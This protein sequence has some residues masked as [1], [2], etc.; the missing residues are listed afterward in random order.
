M[1]FTD[2]LVPPVARWGPLRWL[3]VVH[4]PHQIAVQPSVRPERVENAHPAQ[5]AADGLVEVF[6]LTVLAN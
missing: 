5:D 2:T 4:W 6:L 1:I 3:A